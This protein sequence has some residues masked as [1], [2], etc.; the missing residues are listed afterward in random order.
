LDGD[1]KVE[2]EE[3]TFSNAAA[4]IPAPFVGRGEEI[5]R[6]TQLLA[7]TAV[8][9]SQLAV[10]SGEPGIGKSRLIQE[11]AVLASRQGFHALTAHCYQVEQTM[12]YQPLIDLTRQMMADDDG[13]RQLAPVWL[14]ELAVLAPEIE[15][16]AAGA[17]AVS[18]PTGELDENQQGRLFQAIFHLVAN[19]AKQRKLLLVV[20]DIHW[21]DPATLQCLHYLSRRA[22]R[23]PIL[24]IFSFR[25]EILAVNADLAALLNSLRREREIAFFSLARLS[26]ADTREM[27]AQ[28]T[29]TAP[30]AASLGR[31]LYRETE[32]NPFFFVSLLQSVREEGLLENGMQTDW[33][34]L[35]RTN[36]ALAL[37]DAIRDAVR[38]R[39]GRLSPKEREALD[40]MAVYGRRLDFA[41]LQ[42]IS[43]YPQITLLNSVE[44]LAARQL[45]VESAGQYDF[46]HNKIREAVYYDLSAARC[47]LYHRQI[48]ETLE[49]QPIAPE[50]AAFLAHHFERGRETEK[51]LAYW[52]QAGRQALETYAYQQAARHFERAL[53]LAERPAEKIDAYLGLGNAF[54]LL[55]DHAAATAVIQQGVHLVERLGD[56]TRKAKLLYTQ[57]QNASRQ[58]HPDGGKPAVKAALAAAEQAGDAYYLTQSLLLLT[59]VHESNGDLGDALETAVRAQAVSNHLNNGR[60]EARVLVEIGFLHAQRAEFDAA[61]NAAESGLALLAETDDR[62]AIAYAWNILGRALGGRGDYARA[63][64]AFQRSRD[65]AHII[66]DRYLA[67]QFFNMQGWLYRELG[68]YENGLKS[69]EE[70][71]ATAKE[72]GKPSPEISARLNVCLDRLHLGEAKQVLPLLDEIEAQIAAGSFGFHSWRWRLR[73]LH[74]RGLCLLA[75]GEPVPVLELAKTGL[76][77]AEANVTRKYI[78]L[79]HELRGMALAKLGKTDEAAAVMETAVALADLIHYQ[80]IRWAGRQ[81]LAALYGGDGRT[82]DAQKIRS[83]A[84][85]IIQ[86][87]AASLEN[88]PLR[89]TFLN[90]ALILP[91]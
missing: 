25:A 48:A 66:G 76:S 37:P 64:D 28:T 83:E 84:E 19:H 89:T 45:I 13:W 18:L 27:L 62:N 26:E 75:L 77:L 73:L 15:E 72:W 88:E 41:A 4:P 80:P 71:V 22:V 90:A 60:L 42:A 59:E 12:P 74:A 9:Q 55:D 67:A 61:V 29:D 10:V 49:G 6:F 32:G 5:D 36:P 44:R 17:T 21:A 20:E 35:A 34:A 50:E 56:D 91:R 70:G 54:I 57:A 2:A 8:N 65:M 46:N 69:D 39:L 40:W 30:D 53:A 79:N 24:L 43:R 3:W 82:Q 68:D 86:T 1:W 58:H 31:W 78:A 23:V 87:I 85:Q 7:Q 33:T 16:I 51:A 52:M 81:R 63:F 47:T 11:T 14:R 38:N